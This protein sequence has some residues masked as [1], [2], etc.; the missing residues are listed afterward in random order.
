MQNLET[1]QKAASLY[2]LYWQESEG[3]G[4]QPLLDSYKEQIILLGYPN[5]ENIIYDNDSEPLIEWANPEFNYQDF[6]QEI[7]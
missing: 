5:P 6:I 1:D 2:L 7:L 4:H 3:R